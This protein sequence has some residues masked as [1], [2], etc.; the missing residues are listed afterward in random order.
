MYSS[1]RSLQ[2]ERSNSVNSFGLD[3]ESHSED[4]EFSG[5]IGSIATDNNNVDI[6]FL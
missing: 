3:R 5:V 4:T 1:L 2:N 6:G